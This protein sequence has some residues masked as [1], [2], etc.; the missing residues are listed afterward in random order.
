M[1]LERSIVGIWR[2]GESIHQSANSMQGEFATPESAQVYTAQ[3]ADAVGSSRWD[4]AVR[5]G[6]TDA[7]SRQQCAAFVAAAAV[8]KHPN[9]IPVLDASVESHQPY[10][11]MPRLKAERLSDRWE[12]QA[13][14]PLAG[15]LWMVRQVA[16]ALEAMHDAGWVHGD[17]KPDNIML[18]TGGHATLIDLGFASQIHS[19][20]RGIFQ[21]TP[22]YASPEAMNGS[23][24]VIPAMDTF[25]LGRV[26]WQCLNYVAQSPWDRAGS[27]TE[28]AASLVSAMIHPVAGERPE[29]SDVV[30]RLFDLELQTL[31]SHIQPSRRAA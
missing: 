3:P 19:V 15:A 26:L 12:N 4:Y 22:A 1:K 5:I 28:V 2:L 18:D 13:A 8:S 31:G 6:A 30:Q 25:S 29:M 7:R 17:V 9:L 10:V 23:H 14:M 21:G 24:A 27:T 11:V 20:R 16:Q